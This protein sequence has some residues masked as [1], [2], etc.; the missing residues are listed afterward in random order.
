VRR[1][2]NK[3]G[4]VTDIWLAGGNLKPE[5]VLAAEMERRYGSRKERPAR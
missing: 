3:S 1:T 5:N 2:H 4:R